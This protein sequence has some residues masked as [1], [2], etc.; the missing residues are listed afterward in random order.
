MP[1][2]ELKISIAR[3]GLNKDIQPTSLQGV[4]SPNMINMVVETDLIRK[5]LGYSKLGVNLPLVGTGM[6]LIQYTDAVGTIH[7]IAITDKAA[8]L[9]NSDIDQWVP[10]MPSL[11]L[12]DCEGSEVDS[13][14]TTSA[15]TGKLIEI[16]QNFVTTISVDDIIHNTTDDT[17][18]VVTVVDDNSNLT[19]IPD[20]LMASGDAYTIHGDSDWTAGTN[21]KAAPDP[22]T[23]KLGTYSLRLTAE[24]V[25][26]AGTEIATAELSNVDCS[27][28]SIVGFWL[29]ADFANCQVTVTIKQDGG[30]DVEGTSIV[31]PLANKWYYAMAL[32]DLSSLNSADDLAIDTETA[33]ANKNRIF[34]D[35][36]RVYTK[37]TGDVDDR[38]SFC[39]VTD[40]TM[41]STTGMA[42]LI[43]NNVDD[44]YYYEGQSGDVFNPSTN[45]AAV[46]SKGFD[47]TNFANV[48]EI[49]EFWNHFFYFNLTTSVT[50][51]RG[52]AFADL[53]DIDDWSGGTSGAG[54]LTDTTGEI[55]RVKKLGADLILYSKKSITI[56]K[57]L[58]GQFLFMFP[59]VIHETGLF[60]PKA[61]WG[62]V[63]YHIFLSTDLKVYQ[64][65]GGSQ[66]TDVGKQIEDSLFSEL[67]A[68]KKARVTMGIDPINHKLF[69]FIPEA[70]DTYA[71][72]YYAL[73]YKNPNL[74]WEHG[75]FRDSVRGMSVFDNE[76][77]WYCDDEDLKDLFCD[78]VDFY[79]D[80]AF[81]QSGNPI[82]IF[83]S[84]NGY[85]YQLDERG[86]H[87]GYEIEALYETE[88]AT[89]DGEYV[90]CRW[91]W[92]SFLG[93]S[94]IVNSTVEVF[95]SIYDG[96]EWSEWVE[97]DT[98]SISLTDR[99]TLYRLP[100]DS[101]ARKV[102]VRFYQPAESR[103]IGSSRDLQIRGNMIFE[104]TR[105][106]AK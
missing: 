95:Y 20:A 59:T 36:I 100:F 80:G 2:E 64:Y 44:I 54:V 82:A 62:F 21:M 69:I 33:M 19:V 65:S 103:A 73:N 4:F 57:Y 83:I 3:R 101:V 45:L 66:L 37:F 16:G 75:H 28:Y 43:S 35:D 49:E 60:A 48:K 58:G 29:R 32:V 15:A 27:G 8:Y 9:Y 17:Y 92:F 98:S 40:P 13:G 18:G 14:T 79:C 23:V 87:D 90:N 42:L 81:S 30:T 12:N 84:D 76:R 89:P 63:N 105:E 86:T 88:E 1:I 47:F 26:A 11:L 10:I 55:V 104:L 31:I 99:W 74:P 67:D 78:E 38:F 39:K 53:G 71:K 50:S 41:F 94:D 34:I 25:I 52:F 24:A 56:G 7:Q 68:S 106:T 46:S 72:S 91:H 85:V 96:A 51:I 70:G 6:E 97:F 22:E 5:H 77:D 102:K 93:K 61:I